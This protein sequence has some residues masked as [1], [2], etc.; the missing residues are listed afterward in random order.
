MEKLRP[1]G[2]DGWIVVEAE[3]N[4]ITHGRKHTKTEYENKQKENGAAG[5]GR[6]ANQVRQKWV[7]G[8]KE[9]KN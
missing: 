9:N 5:T 2:E 6:E 3:S 8:E 1:H 4:I 7:K